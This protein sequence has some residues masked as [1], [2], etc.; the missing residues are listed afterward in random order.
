[1]LKEGKLDVISY[2]HEACNRIEAVEPQIHALIPE[3][4]RRN[5]LIKEAEELKVRYPDPDR[6]PPLYGILVGVKDIYRVDG[7]ETRA[8]SKLPSELFYA[9]EA[10]VVKRLRAAGALILGKTVTTEFAYFHPGPTRNP[11]NVMHTPGGS[12]SGSSAGVAAGFF[13]LALGTQTIGSII[14]PAAFCGIVGFKPSYGRINTEGLIYCSPS[15]DHVGLFTQDMAGMK[16][17][18]SVLC[19]NWIEESN[20]KEG[21]KLPVLGVPNG[22]YLNQ[23]AKEELVIFYNLLTKLEE[24]G[25]KVVSVPAFHDINEINLRHTSLVFAELAK[26]HTQWFAEYE[27]LYS[28]HTVEAITSGQAVSEVELNIARMGREK[29]R[30]ELE[31]LMSQ[32]G[33]D[34]WLSPAALGPAPKE[35]SSTGSPIMNLPWTHSGMPTITVPTAYAENDLP[36]GLQITGAFMKDERLLEWAEEIAKSV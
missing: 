14:R 9:P 16:L 23:V 12:S 20:I 22:Q 2:I 32:H 30:V 11:H 26:V 36:R 15:V 27:S 33:I 18:C 17:A 13:P 8:G 25:Y 6:R 34:L 4:N 21:N 35:I 3:P 29:L 24:Q 28:K 5:R 31:E 7:F 1:M 10:E 19:D